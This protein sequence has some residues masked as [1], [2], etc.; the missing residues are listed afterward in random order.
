MITLVWVVFLNIILF[1][2]THGLIVG[3]LFK[4]GP[5][6]VNE[7]LKEIVGLVNAFTSTLLIMVGSLVAKSLESLDWKNK[8]FK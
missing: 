7:S 5:E 8:I 4:I 2:L 6:L 3:G 1:G